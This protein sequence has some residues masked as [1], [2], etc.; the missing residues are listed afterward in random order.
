[1]GGVAGHMDHL[2]ENPNLTF[3]KM[4][5]IMAAASN[6]DLDVEEKVDGQNLFLS[7]SIPEG[8]AKGARN[9]GNLRS[10][11]L[12]AQEL[13]LKFSGRGNLEKAFTG[14]FDTFE[15]AVNALSD[16]E[17]E[18]IFGPD[19]NIWYNAEIMDP[20]SMNVIKYDSKTL[21][22]HDVGHFIFDKNTDDKTPIPNG[23]LDMLD[24]VLGKMKNILHQDDFSLARKAIVQLKRLDD[25]SVLN[26][27]S[28]EID[29]ALSSEGLSGKSTVQNYMFSRLL[30][31]IDAELPEDLKKEI[32]RYL[33]K[34]PG[35]IGLRAL[36]KGLK[37]E[38]LQDLKSII[39]SKKMLL[40]DAIQPIETAVHD[41]T[42]EILKGMKSIF[43]AD[44]DKEV[45]RLKQELAIAVEKLTAAGSEDPQA[46]DILQKHLNKIKD[47]S[48]ITTPVEAVVFDYEGHTYKFSG[49][50]APLNQILGMFRYPTGGK[51][52]TT[53][54]I[55]FDKQVI[56]EKDGKKVA[57][58]PGG[59][60]PPHA[61]HYGL[62]K[63][64]ASDP[65]ITEVVVI[66]GKNPRE[67][68]LAP[69]ITVTAE[70]SKALWDI[71]TRNDENIK[72]RV[73]EGK[74]P[75]ADVYDLIADKN[76]FSDGDT[77]VLGKSDKDVGD[78]RYAR[79][80]SWAEMN[81]PGV[82]IEEMVFPVIGGESMGGTALRDMIATGQ[83][84]KF[85]SKL[86]EHLNELEAEGIWNI[87]SVNHNEALDRFVDSKIEEMS[88][89][90][91]G[92][93][94][95]AGGGSAFGEPNRYNAF[96]TNRKPKVN[97]PKVKKAKRQRRR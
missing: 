82:N 80:Q 71:Y 7:Y 27:V 59:F 13:A 45:S 63:L 61:G 84:E 64:L 40:K 9:K 89:M 49:N 60:K 20:G 41:F 96:K 58:L 32:V 69:K 95:G 73:Q 43:I 88:A 65:N 17:K 33:M 92:G 86:P 25:D 87:V 18:R 31:G 57:L 1:M 78:K 19:T 79:A 77:V 91:S 34:L 47:F 55:N 83:K 72:V 66:I 24:S 50:F 10:G 97:R 21:K 67:S 29:S 8:K 48:K 94:E 26:K 76:S 23:T 62:A 14:G 70:Q 2:Y 22:I 28:S 6:A 51:S 74:T 4:K 42:V 3:S 35:N 81:N 38:D 90:S 56:T 85:I 68:V 93:V 15:K 37:E 11:G 52:I 16:K 12:N 46:M 75:V 36:K 44:N 53:E 54:N 5:E 39:S 30:N